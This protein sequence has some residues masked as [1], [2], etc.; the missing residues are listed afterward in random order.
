[1]VVAKLGLSWVDLQVRT[2]GGGEHLDDG[3]TTTRH[4]RPEHVLETI[5]ITSKELYEGRP[6]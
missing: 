3:Y 6:N 2:A 5:C 1:M 4:T